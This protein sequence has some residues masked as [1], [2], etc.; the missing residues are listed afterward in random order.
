MFRNLRH[1]IVQR[2]RKLFAYNLR[3]C[4][5]NHGLVFLVSGVVNQEVLP[6]VNHLLK[7]VPP[8]GDGHQVVE[9]LGGGGEVFQHELLVTKRVENVFR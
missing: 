2:D 6:Q 9:E 7:G 8:C 5:N 4:E 1:I 3:N